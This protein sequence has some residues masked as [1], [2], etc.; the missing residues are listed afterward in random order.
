MKRW[1]AW[2]LSVMMLLS[3]GCAQE[4]ST[5]D[6]LDAKAQNV[7]M[8]MIGGEYA[9]VVAQFDETMAAAVSTEALKMGWEGT[10]A[11]IGALQ[12]AA[13]VPAQEEEP[14]HAAFAL[15]GERGFVYMVLG[16]DGEGRINEMVITAPQ[17]S[18]QANERALPAGAQAFAVQIPAAQERTLPGELIV[19]ADM[20]AQTPFVVMAQGSGPSD[21]DESIGGNKPFRDLAYDLAALGVGSLRFDKVTFAHPDLPVETIDQEY[22]EPVAAALALLKEATAAERVYLVGHSE[23]GMLAPY[24][25]ERCGFDGGVALAGTPKQLWEISYAQ[26][27]AIIEL[28]PAEQQPLLMQQIAPEYEKALRLAQMSDEEAAVTPVFGMSAVYLRHMARLDQAQ[29]A[30]DSGKPFLFLWGEADFQVDR[31]AF[32]AWNER[33]GDDVR[34]EYRTYPGLNHLFMPAGENDSILHAQAAYQDAK[35]MEP[36]VAR[37]IAAWIAAQ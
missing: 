33:L 29:I 35:Q 6:A 19:P 37:D 2:M 27:L 12:S 21:M 8:Q 9:S 32:E 22:L 16:F 17:L 7:L 23:G 3:T 11:Q 15:V 5:Q 26:N 4:R 34:F 14:V 31:A 1:F 24:L 10:L 36:Q 18:V 25:V 30:K 13:P 20:N 28:M